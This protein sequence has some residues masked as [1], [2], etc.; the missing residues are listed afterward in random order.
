M[1]RAGTAGNKRRCTSAASV[2]CVLSRSWDRSAVVSASRVV[3]RL[4]QRYS[5]TPK[6][7]ARIRSLTDR[8]SPLGGWSAPA[9]N[10]CSQRTA[11]YKKQPR[12]RRRRRLVARL[13][14]CNPYRGVRRQITPVRR[15]VLLGEICWREVAEHLRDLRSLFSANLRPTGTGRSGP[16]QD[17]FPRTRRSSVVATV[18]HSGT[19]RREDAHVS[20]RFCWRTGCLSTEREERR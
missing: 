13:S 14:L 12:R 9:T 19:L 4:S 16:K 8:I 15:R 1:S 6:A 20:A 17:P 18:A 10:A 5:A 7:P 3:R 2:S 11:A